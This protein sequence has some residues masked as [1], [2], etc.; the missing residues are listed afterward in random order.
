MDVTK[1]LLRSLFHEYNELYFDGKLGK[2][3]FSF[4]AKNLSILGSY[5]SKNDK[6]GKKHIIKYTVLIATLVI[7]AMWVV[8]NVPTFYE[9]IGYRIESYI[10]GVTGAAE[11]GASAAIRDEMRKIAMARWLESPIFGYGFD[12]FKYYNI[13]ATGNFFYS[14]CNYTEMLY[15]GGIIYLIVYYSV[16]CIILKKAFTSKTALLK[17]RAFAIGVALSFLV[18]DYGCVS[19]SMAPIQI[20]LAMSLHTLAFK[21]NEQKPAKSEEI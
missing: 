4:F 10:N 7:F 12:S 11:Q 14:H 17:Y 5:N 21:N 2:C 3:D 16:F 19:Y 13:T 15:S 1:E 9:T 20:M 18:F 6:N 8:M